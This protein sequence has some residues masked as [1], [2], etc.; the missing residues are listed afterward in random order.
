MSKSPFNVIMEIDG[1]LL[2]P[3]G[4]LNPHVNRS[5]LG[6]LN[7]V[8]G[9]MPFTYVTALPFDDFGSVARNLEI[10]APHAL[11]ADGVLYTSN[12]DGSIDE[13]LCEQPPSFGF[14]SIGIKSGSDPF[15]ENIRHAFHG[16][17]LEHHLSNVRELVDIANDNNNE[18]R[19]YDVPVPLPL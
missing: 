4:S 12:N 3:D 10:P 1:L 5:V 17:V 14:V 8:E 11:V 19:S 13:C 18:E 16:P 6:Y 9:I 15:P 2:N 7:D